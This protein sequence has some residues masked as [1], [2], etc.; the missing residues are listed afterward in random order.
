MSIAPSMVNA[1]TIDATGEKLAWCGGFVHQDR[2]AKDITRV[3]F[4]FGSSLIKAGG[5]SLTVSLQDVSATAAPLQ[6]DETQDQTVAIANGDAGFA[7]STWYRT[8][9]LS[10]N[11]TVSHGE[12][13]AVVLE[14]DGG[15]RLGGLGADAGRAGGEEEGQGKGELFHRCP[16]PSNRIGARSQTGSEEVWKQRPESRWNEERSAVL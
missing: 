1:A 15:G 14:F 2:A 9:A 6:P 16:D 13:L 10:A 8:G 3:G 11:R 7:S 12:Q 4:F 5:S